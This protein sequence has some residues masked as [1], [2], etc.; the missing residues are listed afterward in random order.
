MGLT[1]VLSP[2]GNAGR[3]DRVSESMIYCAVDVGTTKTSAAIAERDGTAVVVRPARLGRDGDTASS[4]VFVADDGFVH[5][6]SAEDR[7]I[8]QPGRLLRDVKRRVGD[9]VP[10]LVAG[11]SVT[12]EE[13]FART[14]AWAVAT[15]SAGREL[16]GLMVTVPAAWGDHRRAVVRAALAARGLP[17]AT[18]ISEPEA[19]AYHYAAQQGW[20]PGTV[21]AVYDLG[22]GSCD[23]AFVRVG[24]SRGETAV[25][26]AAGIADLGGSD[27]DDAVVAHVLATVGPAALGLVPAALA[28]LRRACTTAKEAL[29]VDAEA[30]VPFG[31][32]G[33]S[34]RLVRSEFETMIEDDIARTV[35]AFAAAREAAGIDS[36]RIAAVLLSGGSSRIPRVAQLLSQELELTLQTDADPKAV[37]A[38]GAARAKADAIAAALTAGLVALGNAGGAAAADDDDAAPSRPLAAALVALRPRRWRAAM[39]GTAAVATLVGGLAFGSSVAAVAVDRTPASGPA[40][41]AAGTVPVTAGALLSTR[42]EA[43]ET[44][45][46]LKPEPAPPAVP[47]PT[48]P[49]PPVWSPMAPVL[50]AE[51]GGDA[52]DAKTERPR[53]PLERLL[54]PAI[55]TDDDAASESRTTTPT[56]PA[57]TPTPKATHPFAPE[58][59]PAPVPTSTPAPSPSPTAPA[60]PAP[61][62]TTDPTPTPTPTPTPEP[63]TTPEPTPDPQPA[64]DPEPSPDPEPAPTPDPEPSPDPQPTSDPAPTPDPTPDP[65]PDP[66]PDPTPSPEPSTS[67]TPESMFDT[68]EEQHT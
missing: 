9:D 36:D 62:P 54:G 55:P 63:T 60:Q 1:N 53:G 50:D 20:A 57:A 28:A 23:V 11:R 17:G 66:A 38:L 32:A 2:W 49:A 27:F 24:E 12:G 30:V 45:V 10:L 14:V 22:A 29:S 18:L 25:L 56:T 7:G 68:G 4:A 34:V 39:T 31:D 21:L 42:R 58:P 37:V 52:R 35:D 44:P 48:P 5:G 19:A 3:G 64:P 43:E 41:S 61:Q 59:T 65:E 51:R 13:L 47:A 8:A 33:R 16:G 15:A 40:V 67:P 6:D 26:H 46:P